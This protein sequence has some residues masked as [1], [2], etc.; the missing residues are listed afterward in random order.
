MFCAELPMRMLIFLAAFFIAGCNASESDEVNRF[1][2]STL[3][4][5]RSGDKTEFAK[6]PVFPGYKISDDAISMIFGEEGKKGVG[7]FLAKIKPAIKIFGPQAM[8]DSN[9][10][11]VYFIVY[12][13]PNEIES[14]KEGYFDSFE[15]KKFWGTA[16]LET[17]ITVVDNKAMF[18]RTPFYYGAH[19]PWAEDY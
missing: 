3:A 2:E 16:Y 19:A 4:L 12:Y 6:L 10:Y 8:G 15:I 14:N 11:D 1:A 13:D 7:N 18:H 9:G 5:I 17:I